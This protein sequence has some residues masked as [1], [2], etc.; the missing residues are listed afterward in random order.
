MA[1]IDEKVAGKEVTIAAEVPAAT[2]VVDMI[3]ALKKSLLDAKAPKAEAPKA[4]AK[5]APKKARKPRKR[6]AG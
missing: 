5:P 6:K 2:N 1:A 3:E 4:E